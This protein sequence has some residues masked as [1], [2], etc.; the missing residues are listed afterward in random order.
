MNIFDTHFHLQEED[1]LD[2][3]M[4]RAEAAGVNRFVLAGAPVSVIADTLRRIGQNGSI[5]A[6]VGVHPHDADNFDGEIASYSA[7]L[8]WPRVV[9][10]GEIG[11]D[12]HYVTAE[13]AVQRRVFESFLDLA[14]CRH[15]P[16]VV[17]CRDAFE[18]CYDLIKQTLKG[19]VPFVVH[20]FTGS[21]AWAQ[22]FIDI[23][24]FLSFNG[25]MTFKRSDS[26]RDVLR[27]VPRDRILFETDSPYLA[28]VPMRGKRNEPA[29]MTHIIARA[30]EELDL[31]V[32][33][34]IDLSTSNAL[35][36]F[37]IQ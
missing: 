11:L 26:V 21:K 3:M 5:Y 19:R 15:L 2:G 16:V 20:C 8:D 9:A 17:H 35:R 12:Y 34:L 32:E 18:D 36:F 22:R 25:I 7:Y 6:A 29:Y 37:N 1:D 23:G 30:A 24:G 10:I 33:A 31:P 27:S 28:P 14:A 4:Q 13:K